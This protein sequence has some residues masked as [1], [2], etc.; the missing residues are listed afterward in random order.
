MSKTIILVLFAATCLAQWFV[1]GQM[2]SDRERVLREGKTYKFKTEPIDPSDPFRGKYITLNFEERSVEVL[3]PKEW[4]RAGDI[5]VSIADSAGFAR[6]TKASMYEP[7][8]ID[9]IKAKIAWVD[10]YQPP[11]HVWIQY[12]FD[13]FYVEESKAS[14]AERVSRVTRNDSTTV[15][16]A[17]VCV[18]DGTAALKDVM[19]NDRSIADVVR[20]MNEQELT[21]T[22]I[23]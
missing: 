6:I 21:K 18:L 9:Y 3:D 4:E 2:I 14:K 7:E 19:I 11:Y 13:R 8:G 10:S 1:P 22:D 20:E 15:V 17:V 16:Y 12:P 23:P 5:Y